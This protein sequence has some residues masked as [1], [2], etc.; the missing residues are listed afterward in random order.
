MVRGGHRMTHRAR[1]GQLGLR[2]DSSGT[3]ADCCPAGPTEFSVGIIFP[4]PLRADTVAR[5]VSEACPHFIPENES[6]AS[7]DCQ[8]NFVGGTDVSAVEYDD[9]EAGRKGQRGQ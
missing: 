4:H 3:G 2:V 7:N 8:S 1:R 9:V 5:A 6:E